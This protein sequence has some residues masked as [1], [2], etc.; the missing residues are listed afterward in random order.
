MRF[1]RV[2]VVRKLVGAKPYAEFKAA[3]DSLLTTQ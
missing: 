2:K 1:L 3:F